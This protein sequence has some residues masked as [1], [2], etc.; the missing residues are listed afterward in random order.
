MRCDARCR[1][2]CDEQSDRIW[3]RASG[4]AITCWGTCYLVLSLRPLATA[5]VSFSDPQ[6]RAELLAHRTLRRKVWLRLRGFGRWCCGRVTGDGGAGYR[7]HFN[8]DKNTVQEYIVGSSMQEGGGGGNEEER[9]DGEIAP[10]VPYQRF[11]E[12]Q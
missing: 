5:A 2:W 7:I 12:E 10:D 11:D 6:C 9:P 8:E 3:A 4:P 1:Q